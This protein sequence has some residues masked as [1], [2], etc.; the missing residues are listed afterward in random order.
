MCA[1]ITFFPPKF[2]NEEIIHLKVSLILQLLSDDHSTTQA[3]SVELQNDRVNVIVGS[4]AIARCQ[5]GIP[6]KWLIHGRL[7]SSTYLA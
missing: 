1:N 2:T 5:K 7:N 3:L 6:T 4:A